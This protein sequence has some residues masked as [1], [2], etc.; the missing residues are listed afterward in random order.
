MILQIWG[1]LPNLVTT[2]V[3]QR[4]RAPQARESDWCLGLR[5][6]PTQPEIRVRRLI[7]GKN[8]E[9]QILEHFPE[10]E[11]VL[12]AVC[13][14]LVIFSSHD[15]HFIFGPVP[16]YEVENFTQREQWLLGQRE[17]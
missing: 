5:T 11:S 16:L 8:G 17:F 10:C 13:P 4:C 12:I 9:N 6:G 1:N 7:C 15:P 3:S 2:P 14:L